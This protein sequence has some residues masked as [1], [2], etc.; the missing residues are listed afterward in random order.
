MNLHVM[1]Q[2]LNL[3]GVIDSYSSLRWVRRWVE[4][5]EFELHLD[6]RSSG[7]YLIRVGYFIFK[8]E[9]QEVMKMESIEIKDAK[10]TIKGHSVA[11]FT[12]DRITIPEFAYVDTHF[13]KGSTEH[14]LKKL[15]EHNCVYPHDPKRKIPNL[16]LAPNLDRGIQDSYST[17]YKP[18]HE[19]LKTIAE[20][21]GLG[22]DIYLDHDQKKLVFDVREG[23]DRSAEQSINPR[24]IFSVD[25]EN[26][27]SRGMNISTV[28]E[29]TVAFVGGQGEGKDRKIIILDDHLS[30]LERKEMFVDARDVGESEEIKPED[31]EKLLVNRGR[32]RLKENARINGIECRVRSKANIIYRQDY[33]L[34]DIVTVINPDWGIKL[35]APITEAEEVYEGESITLDLT[36]GTPP[37]TLKKQIKREMR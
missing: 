10:M 18:L 30:G 26:L 3:V 28:G 4:P 13:L 24:A 6:F 2:D 20:L 14:I 36:F 23:V 22:W 25:F 37:P 7:A 27:A 19:E 33:D 11:A 8:S 17:R 5:G 35:T 34:G 12:T 16:I 29:K 31:V 32:E 1:D 9:D 21:G 15:V